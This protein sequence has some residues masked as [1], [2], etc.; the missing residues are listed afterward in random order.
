MNST[1]TLCIA[2]LATL[3]VAVARAGDVEREVRRR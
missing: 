3:P 1:R 2:L